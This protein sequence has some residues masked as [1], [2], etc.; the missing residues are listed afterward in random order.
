M[1]PIRSLSGL[2]LIAAVLM[3]GC[4]RGTKRTFEE[5]DV[6]EGIVTLDGVP[7]AKGRIL[8]E[9][10]EDAVLGA[11]PGSGPISEGH[12]RVSVSMGTKTVRIFAPKV[13]GEVDD[14]GLATTQET[15]PAH[16][17]KNSTL[18]ATISADGPRTFDF[19]LTPSA[20]KPSRRR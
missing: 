15:I 1:N 9:S 5:R 16:Y 3:V 12:Y 6:V 19:D 20:G 4:G 17:N 11:P 2:L 18:E 10:P 13:V 8:F 7:L 14:M